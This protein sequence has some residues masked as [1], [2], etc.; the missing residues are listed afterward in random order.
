M[1]EAVTAGINNEAE[2]RAIITSI[3]AMQA[4]VGQKTFAYR[5]KEFVSIIADHM[6]ILGPFMPAL[7]QLLTGSH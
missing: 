1:R 4:E 2:Q 5:Y 7:A 3:T 6:G